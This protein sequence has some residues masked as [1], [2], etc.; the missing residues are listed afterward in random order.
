MLLQQLQHSAYSEAEFVPYPIALDDHPLQ[1][2]CTKLCCLLGDVKTLQSDSPAPVPSRF[3]YQVQEPFTP[4][5]L[6][7]TWTLV[8][9][10]SV[11]D[12]L[13]TS[14]IGQNGSYDTQLAARGRTQTSE[15]IIQNPQEYICPLNPR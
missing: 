1:S 12:P 2:G 13:L 8:Q 10:I 3:E 14:T 7:A 15:Y 6:I 9:Q 11:Q 4:D 5:L